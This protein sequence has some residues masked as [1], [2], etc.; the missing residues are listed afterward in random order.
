[1]SPNQ[2][3]HK[4]HM[5]HQILKVEKDTHVSPNLEIKRNLYLSPKSKNNKK[6][7]YA[8]QQI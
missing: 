2:K 6:K 1:M 7:I 5:C 4:T 8:C 3:W